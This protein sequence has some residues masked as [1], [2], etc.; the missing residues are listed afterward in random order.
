MRKEEKAKPKRTICGIISGRMAGLERR[1]TSL[2]F[3]L[4]QRLRHLLV[5]DCLK[6][7]SARFEKAFLCRLNGRTKKILSQLSKS[8]VLRRVKYDEPGNSVERKGKVTRTSFPTQP[9]WLATSKDFNEV[10]SAASI[11]PLNFVINF[12]I[13]N[14]ADLIEFSARS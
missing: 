5:D 4:F 8:R 7:V 14:I 12:I 1:K 3:L 13:L 2:L 10:E 9:A 11:E 6:K